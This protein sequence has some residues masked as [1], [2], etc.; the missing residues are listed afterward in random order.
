MVKVI[1]DVIVWYHGLSDSIVSKRDSVFTLKF[2]SSLCYFLGL[3]KN[4]LSLFTLI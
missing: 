2:W 4:S 3:N 1:M